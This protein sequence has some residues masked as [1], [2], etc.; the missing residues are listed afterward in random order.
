MTPSL[1][2][3]LFPLALDITARLGGARNNG[4][5]S[6]RHEGGILP[7]ALSLPQARGDGGE[8]NPREPGCGFG[9]QLCPALAVWP[10]IN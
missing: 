9:S 3:V 5:E 7:R 6:S 8:W 4:T 10:S 2:K 1:A